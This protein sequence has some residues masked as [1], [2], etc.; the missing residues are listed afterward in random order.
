MPKTYEHKHSVKQLQP[1][2]VSHNDS[3]RFQEGDSATIK[4]KEDFYAPLR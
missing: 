1:D 2:S 4:A 3:K